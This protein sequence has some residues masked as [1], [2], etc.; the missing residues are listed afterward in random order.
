MLGCL[1]AARCRR[2]GSQ[3]RNFTNGQTCSVPDRL[4]KKEGGVATFASYSSHSASSTYLAAVLTLSVGEC[5]LETAEG[6]PTLRTQWE[7]IVTSAG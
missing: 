7:L 3:H 5:S 6:H 4:E 2:G 1:G